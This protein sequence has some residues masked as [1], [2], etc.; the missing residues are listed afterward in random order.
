MAELEKNP[1]SQAAQQQMDS[2][3]AAGWEAY[4]DQQ[5]V[6]AAEI[7]GQ[8][9]EIAEAIANTNRIVYFRF[10]QGVA[11]LRVSKNGH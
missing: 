8:S 7:Y 3:S 9:L 10:M 2:L 1:I 11:L 6:R 5:L 4:K